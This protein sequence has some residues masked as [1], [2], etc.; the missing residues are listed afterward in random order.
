MPDFPL[1]QTPRLLLREITEADVEDLFRIH[2]DARHMAW[3]GTDPLTD[4]NEAKRLIATFASWR[5]LP[6]PG[7][8]WGLQLKDQP[9]LIGSCGLFAWNRGWK[10]CSLGYEVAPEL[11]GRGLMREALTAALDWG[12]GEGM[13]LHR[14][15]AQ[16]HEDNVASVALLQRLG[17]AREGRLREVAFWGGRHHDLL[18]YGLLAREWREAAGS[19]PAI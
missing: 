8:R 14:V 12:F 9:G 2:S 19:R 18:Q 1:L 17:F 13:Q 4:L 15:E 5:Q 16:V 6:N 3:F 11:A 10:K 7:V